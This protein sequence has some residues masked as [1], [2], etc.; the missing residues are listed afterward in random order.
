MMG[1][2]MVLMIAVIPMIAAVILRLQQQKSVIVGTMMGMGGWTMIRPAMTV[3]TM[4]WMM[5]IC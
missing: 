4:M 2:G 1:M 5:G 3:C